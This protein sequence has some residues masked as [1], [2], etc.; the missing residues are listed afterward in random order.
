MRVVRSQEAHDRLLN[1]QYGTPGQHKYIAGVSHVVIVSEYPRQ[2]YR[3]DKAKHVETKVVYSPEE[4]TA[5]AKAGW[6]VETAAAHEVLEAA[7][8]AHSSEPEIGTEPILDKPKVRIA[9]D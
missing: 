7:Q 8:R 2:V 4:A 1:P 3:L 5:A 9:K 6:A